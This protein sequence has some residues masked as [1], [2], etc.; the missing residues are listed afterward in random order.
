MIISTLHRFL[1]WV[2]LLPVVVEKSFVAVVRRA[3]NV[4]R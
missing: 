2:V 3:A 4:S 1:V